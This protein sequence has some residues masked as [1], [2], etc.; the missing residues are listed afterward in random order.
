MHSPAQ[1]NALVQHEVF[2]NVH[3]V[4][5]KLGSNSGRAT[6][7]THPTAAGCFRHKEIPPVCSC[8]LS[9]LHNPHEFTEQAT[10]QTC[11]ATNIGVSPFPLYSNTIQV[12]AIST[13]GAS[14][15]HKALAGCWDSPGLKHPLASSETIWFVLCYSNTWICIAFL[16][17]FAG[18]GLLGFS[19]LNSTV[20]PVTEHLM[21]I[22]LQL[23]HFHHLW[24]TIS[25]QPSGSTELPDC[26]PRCKD[27]IVELGE[28]VF[29]VFPKII[30]FCNHE[31]FHLQIRKQHVTLITDF[32]YEKATKHHY[33]ILQLRT[34]CSTSPTASDF[35][36]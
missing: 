19:F 10:A 31:L 35:A 7:D 18:N 24:G 20:L 2:E 32:A 36:R 1:K 14:L 30:S 15:P 28:V 17:Y 12:V 8:V 13:L 3:V 29:H 34:G 22:I 21:E 23:L 25:Y 33:H 26:I 16:K 9:Q 5:L 4:I 27:C 11:K 6:K